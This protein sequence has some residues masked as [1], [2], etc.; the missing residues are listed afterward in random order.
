MKRA[1]VCG[2][3]AFIGGHLVNKLEREG[4]WVRGVD[5][6][7]HEFAPTRAD[8]FLLLDLREPDN[9]RQ[10]LTLPG[11]EARE[12]RKMSRAQSVWSWWKGV[13]RKIGDVQGRLLL[14]LFY[15]LLL[16]PF[17]LV[18]RWWSDPLAIKANAPRGWRTRDDR[19]GTPIERAAR[20]F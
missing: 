12:L 15:F 2:A 11:G 6:K 9:C 10:A 13:A 7:P 16:A 19:E 1:L 3:G 4:Y 14:I 8:E 18:V 17:A 5:I 20:Q